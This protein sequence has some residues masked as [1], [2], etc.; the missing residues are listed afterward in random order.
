MNPVLKFYLE[1]VKSYW[2]HIL[3]VIVIS[4]IILGYAMLAHYPRMHMYYIIVEPYK[5]GRADLVLEDPLSLNGIIHGV[6]E[7]LAFYNITVE[8]VHNI[9]RKEAA[10]IAF[11]VINETYGIVDYVWVSEALVEDFRVI[12]IN[13][14][15]K[16]DYIPSVIIGNSE[17]LDEGK[18]FV[19]LINSRKIV[20]DGYVNFD[21]VKLGLGGYFIGMPVVIPNPFESNTIII[22]N[23]SS[24]YEKLL[25][26]IEK[27]VRFDYVFILTRVGCDSEYS[28]GIGDVEAEIRYEILRVAGF[29]EEIALNESRGTT[30]DILK[31]LPLAAKHNEELYHK[32][33]GM[34]TS[35]GITFLA[36]LVIFITYII[37]VAFSDVAERMRDIIALA[38]ALGSKDYQVS[39]MLMLQ[40][41]VYIVPALFIGLVINYYYLKLAADIYFPFRL[42]FLWFSPW[43]AIALIVAGVVAVISGLY[44]IR[45][46]PLSEVLAGG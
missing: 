39:L 9:S 17:A 34:R 19:Y 45:R 36:A 41:I 24:A 25:D 38:Y 2:R 11:R 23:G 8:G 33:Y 43:I 7:K 42:L 14:S 28:P 40:S 29:P 35:W 5:H 6:L 26:K 4:S 10:D 1:Y 27:A 18:V 30:R 22:A 20:A 16:I 15:S 44:G 37:R 21:G 46:R 3:K 12:I 13:D 32:E 31:C